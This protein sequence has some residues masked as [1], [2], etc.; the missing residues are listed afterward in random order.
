ML[1]RELGQIETLRELDLSGT[2]LE[3]ELP[4]EVIRS[5]ANGC[6]IRL[7]A[8]NPG[9][10]LPDDMSSLGNDILK[11]DLSECSL[12]G[13]KINRVNGRWEGSLSAS[14]ICRCASGCS[15]GIAPRPEPR[16]KCVLRGRPQLV[17]PALFIEI[18]E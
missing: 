2:S 4:L 12:H 17:D 1:P 9:F 8:I 5:K 15:S 6:D 13:E 16:S 18:I 3:G 14:P 10:S 7:R 11:L